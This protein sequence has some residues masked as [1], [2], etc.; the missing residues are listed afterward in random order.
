MALIKCPKCGKQFSE[1]AE[2]C[3][4]CG[5]TIKEIKKIKYYPFL[6]P[7]IA[8]LLF[9]LPYFIV[10][11]HWPTSPDPWGAYCSTTVDWIKLISISW[12]PSILSLCACAISFIKTNAHKSVGA[13]I[14]C[15]IMYPIFVLIVHNYRFEPICMCEIAWLCYCI[16]Q[17][18]IHIGILI[19]SLVIN[20]KHNKWTQKSQ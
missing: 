7:V 5:A 3:P 9:L 1:H 12:I 17:L 10:I 19:Y 11:V 14:I 2:K 20:I 13:N 18:V 8:L 16:L 15:V 6:Y 4:Q